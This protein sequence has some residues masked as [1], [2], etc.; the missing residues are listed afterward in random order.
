MSS[1]VGNGFGLVIIR[2]DRTFKYRDDIYKRVQLRKGYP[3]WYRRIEDS[4]VEVPAG[5]EYDLELTF[6]KW[7]K[8]IA[9]LLYP[10]LGDD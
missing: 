10:L 5:K 6:V 9:R 2:D 1:K 3:K 8:E 4:W 7:E